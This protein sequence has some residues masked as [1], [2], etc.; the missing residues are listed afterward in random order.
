MVGSCGENQYVCTGQKRYERLIHRRT[1]SGRISKSHVACTSVRLNTSMKGLVL[2][3]SR[4]SDLHLDDRKDTPIQCSA[5]TRKISWRGLSTIRTP[6][7]QNRVWYRLQKSCMHLDHRAP[8]W[9]AA[10]LAYCAI[11]SFVPVIYIVFAITDTV[12]QPSMFGSEILPRAAE[13]PADG[14]F[15]SE[16]SG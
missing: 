4:R 8:S 14:A 6:D 15:G 1:V 2:H 13:S 11:F 3:T 10:A 12:I 16:A 5:W 7:L 9:F